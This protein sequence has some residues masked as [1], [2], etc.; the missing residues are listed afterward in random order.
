MFANV[1]LLFALTRLRKRTEL[2]T[3]AREKASSR[4]AEPAAGISPVRTPTRGQE[5]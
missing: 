3:I 5:K 4:L 2:L 1:A